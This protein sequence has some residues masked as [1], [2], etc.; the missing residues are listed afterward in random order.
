MNDKINV[1]ILGAGRIGKLHAENIVNYVR[2]ANLISIADI[3]VDEEKERWAK[4][5][6]VDLHNDPDKIINDTNIDA[7]L[8]CCLLYTSRCV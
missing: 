3:Y 6:G 1:G 7:V 8:I 2:E 5:I 4:K